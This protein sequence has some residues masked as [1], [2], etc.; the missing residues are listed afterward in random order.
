MGIATV[1]LSLNW[2][3]GA[4]STMFLVDLGHILRLQNH[5]F[6][7]HFDGSTIAPTKTR[8]LKYD[9]PVRSPLN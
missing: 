7:W 9:F 1:T 6:W 2:P 3:I 4:F 8:L 5:L